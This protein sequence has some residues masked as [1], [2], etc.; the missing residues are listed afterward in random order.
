MATWPKITTRQRNYATKLEQ[1]FVFGRQEPPETIA[2]NYTLASSKKL[3]AGTYVWWT[4]QW[5]YGI[6]AWSIDLK[7]KMKSHAHFSKTKRWTPMNPPL[8]NRAIYPI[9]VT[10]DGTSGYTVETQTNYHQK[11]NAWDESLDPSRIRWVRCHNQWSPPKQNNYPDN[12][13]TL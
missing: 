7:Y 6:T 9:Y 1:L 3:S 11:K 5:Q 2:M 8:A 12:Q 13:S 4:R 10:L